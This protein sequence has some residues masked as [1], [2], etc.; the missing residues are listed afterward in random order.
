MAAQ[1]TVTPELQKLVD[2]TNPTR[3][4]VSADPGHRPRRAAD[5]LGRRPVG[6]G[7]LRPRARAAT[8]RACSRST[9]SSKPRGSRRWRFGSAPENLE[10]DDL[11]EMVNAGLI[12]AIVV[13]DYLANVLEEGLS[14]PDRPRQHRRAHRRHPRRR[15]PQEQ[16]AAVRG[17]E[18]VHGEVRARNGLWQPDRAASTWSAPSTRRAPRPK[19]SARSS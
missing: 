4:N 6:Q 19:P 1:V 9:R 15:R 17:A 3:M 11:L 18:H 8:T 13:D 7:G 2:F 10:D 12:P 5:R 16:P 14:E